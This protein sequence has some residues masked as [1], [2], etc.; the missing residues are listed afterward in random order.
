MTI[1]GK[2]AYLS[3]VSPSQIN[4]Q[5]PDDTASGLVTVAVT[6]GAGQA[7]SAVILGQASPAF[8]LLDA[9]HVTAII[10][11]SNGA[12]RIS[13]LAS[14]SGDLHTSCGS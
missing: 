5:A 9:R 3:M 12:G 13:C 10:L 1:N 6:T 7:I 8:M 4:L 11:R 2:P 14:W